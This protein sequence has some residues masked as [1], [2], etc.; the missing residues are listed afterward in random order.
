ME[1]GSMLHHGSEVGV[2]WL[3]PACDKHFDASDITH[4]DEL[5]VFGW[6]GHLRCNHQHCRC[7]IDTWRGAIVSIEMFHVSENVSCEWKNSVL[8]KK[9]YQ[10]PP[11][12]GMR[13]VS[14]TVWSIIFK[15]SLEQ[16]Q[17]PN[18]WLIA[19]ALPVLKTRNPKIVE[20][21]CVFAHESTHLESTKGFSSKPTWFL[22]K[23]QL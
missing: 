18:D 11:C 2:V 6:I 4:V 14:A 23:F 19:K 15:A 12:A 16:K 3:P 9:K 10:T 13:N 5:C 1:S 21:Y 8:P 20:K 17:V 22:T 7:W